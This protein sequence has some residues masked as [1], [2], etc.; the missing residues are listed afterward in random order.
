MKYLSITNTI[1]KKA[2]PC[3]ALFL[4]LAAGR[5]IGQT[6]AGTD[7]FSSGISV[8]NWIVQMSNGYMT[9]AG[10]NGHVSF[11]VPISTGADQGAFVWWHGTPTAAAD[12]AV[13]ITGHNSVPGSSI[14]GSQL[15]LAVLDKKS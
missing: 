11:L 10:T 7:D 12:W 9:V 15:Q 14:G 2:I 8:T 6:W 3:V 4:L 5:C 1:S 13:S